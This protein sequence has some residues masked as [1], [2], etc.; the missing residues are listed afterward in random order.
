MML[1]HRR[2]AV[3]GLLFTA[4]LGCRGLE[5]GPSDEE[6]IAAVRKSPPLPPTL[7]PTHLAQ[8]DKVEVHERGSYKREGGY[9]PVRIRVNGAARIKVTNALQLG[10][11]DRQA[12]EK[13]ESVEFT[14]EARFT[15]DDFGNWQVFY[16]YDGA[17]PQWRRAV[18]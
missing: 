13:T 17:G 6:V 5:R 16:V 12:R 8:V 7:G 10:I 11:A 18:R 3:A 9:W 1:E 2:V 15:R 14:Q 4:V